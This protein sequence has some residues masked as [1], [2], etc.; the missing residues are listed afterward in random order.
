MKLLLAV[1]VLACLS[2]VLVGGAG[3]DPAP[4]SPGDECETTDLPAG[5]FVEECGR[6]YVVG[7]PRA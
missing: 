4:R 2:G 1:L 3:A 6:E 7:L 5:A